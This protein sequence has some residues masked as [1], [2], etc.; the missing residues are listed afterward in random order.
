M[1]EKCEFET[2]LRARKAPKVSLPESGPV[3][4]S[5]LRGPGPARFGCC[6]QRK[7]IKAACFDWKEFGISS[8]VEKLIPESAWKCL[9]KE[10]C[11]FFF[12]DSTV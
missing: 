1:K 8:S 4:I 11:K 10:Q 6:W 5:D 3:G 7:K 9:N 2:H 12:F